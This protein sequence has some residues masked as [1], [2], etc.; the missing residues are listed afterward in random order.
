M[1]ER[2]DELRDDLDRQ[3]AGISHTVDQIENR[4][5]PG[6]VISRRTYRMRRSMIDWRDRV[7]GNDDPSYPA[8][9]YP[10]VDPRGVPAVY[11]A[12]YPTGYPVTGGRD[13]GGGAGGS[14]GGVS[15]AMHRAQERASDAAHDVGDQVR[16]APEAVRQRTQGAPIGAGLIAFGAGL[17]MASLLPTTRREQ[18]FARDAE[19]QMRRAVEGAK[20][21]A[22]DVAGEM[23]DDLREPARE[24]A[25]Q[26]RQTATEEGKAFAS[27]AKHEAHETRDDVGAAVR[28][29]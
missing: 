18:D 7:F 6:R 20:A 23:A 15:D 9:W 8:H 17:L 14:S 19:P 13:D 2:A 24:A 12:A 1:A 11:P 4:V 22:G 21:V 27:E 29:R 5:L 28:D 25:E 3:R 10:G 16:H 26:V